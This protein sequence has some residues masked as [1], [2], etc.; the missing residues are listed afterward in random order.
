MDNGSILD[1]IEQFLAQAE[2]RLRGQLS[3]EKL[4]STLAEAHEHLTCRAEELTAGGLAPDA[5]AATAVASFG[6]PREWAREILVSEHMTPYLRV[7][8]NISIGGFTLFLLATPLAIPALAIVERDQFAPII[9]L[10]AGA[11]LA[12]AVANLGALVARRCAAKTLIGVVAAAAVVSY[13]V[14][15]L[16]AN[17]LAKILMQRRIVAQA[18]DSIRTDVNL[19]QQGI[20]VYGASTLPAK[21]P[22]SLKITGGFLAPVARTHPASMK[23]LSG[24]S[25]EAVAT[26]ELAAQRW[27]DFGAVR[28]AECRMGLV[29][30]Q[31]RPV[32]HM[33]TLQVFSTFQGDDFDSAIA[34]QAVYWVLIQGAFCLALCF[35]SAQLGRLIHRVHTTLRAQRKMSRSLFS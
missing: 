22:N 28:L 4:A 16:S 7:A 10:I 31:N 29:D 3:P 6:K 23:A 14:I 30:L 2:K 12:F 25:T 20:Q 24:G 15:G 26:E 13:L 8:N 11:A 21:V 1:P 32:T 5:A 27:R 34:Q 35:I 17:P 19:L 9:A 33:N 18:Q